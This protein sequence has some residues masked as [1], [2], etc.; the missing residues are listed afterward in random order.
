MKITKEDHLKGM[1]RFSQGLANYG[2]TVEELTKATKRVGKL[3]LDCY[4]SY[5]EKEYHWF[6]GFRMWKVYF[7]KTDNVHLREKSKFKERLI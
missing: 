3:L 2:V 4:D 7:L 6:F 1:D 5:I